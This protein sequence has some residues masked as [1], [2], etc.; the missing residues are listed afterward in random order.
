[1]GLRGGRGGRGG[2]RGRR[3]EGR[4][5]RGRE[6]VLVRRRRGGSE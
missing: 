3:G 2:G 1:M 5:R 6:T 4:R